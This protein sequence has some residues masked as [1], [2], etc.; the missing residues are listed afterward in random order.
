M[1]VAISNLQQRFLDAVRF[2]DFTMVDGGTKCPL[3][4][5]DCRLKISN[6]DGNVVNFCKQH[7]NSLPENSA[8][9][10]PEG[11]DLVFSDAITLFKIVDSEAL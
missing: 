11:R 9:V 1:H 6:G 2:N 5:V 7:M 10:T 8:G 3:V 4:V